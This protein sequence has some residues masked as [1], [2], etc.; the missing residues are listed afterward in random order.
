MAERSDV[1]PGLGGNILAD[2]L[3]FSTSTGRR[4]ML[5]GA[6]HAKPDI[7]PCQVDQE[8]NMSEETL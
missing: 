6:A 4:E 8:A 5:R 2:E 7:V 3:A 1:V